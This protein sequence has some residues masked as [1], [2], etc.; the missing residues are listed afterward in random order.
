MDGTLSP[1]GLPSTSTLGPLRSNGQST[2]L[3]LTGVCGLT[4][5]RRH[6]LKTNYA[7][8]AVPPWE[9]KC[10][11]GFKPAKH[12]PHRTTWELR[13]ILIVQTLDL[14]QQ[15]TITTA[16][17]QGIVKSLVAVFAFFIFT[18]SVLRTGPLPNIVMDMVTRVLLLAVSATPIRIYEIW[19]AKKGGDCFSSGLAKSDSKDVV[20]LL[21]EVATQLRE[22]VSAQFVDE[23]RWK[24]I[25]RE[26]GTEWGE[27]VDAKMGEHRFQTLLVIASVVYVVWV[28]FKSCYRWS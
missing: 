6:Y 24:T 17:Y 18:I 19:W 16:A 27:F 10:P 26:L 28:I 4:K 8:S 21:T 23:Q 1:V 3:P 14:K 22:E 7:R 11:T 9:W 25:R 15:V 12:W 20:A 13:K 2:A 5:V